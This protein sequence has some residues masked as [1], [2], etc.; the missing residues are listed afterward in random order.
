MTDFDFA[1]VNETIAAAIPEREALVWG[2]RRLTHRVLAERSRRFANFLLSRGLRVGQERKALAGHGARTTSR[3]TST[4]ATS[5]SRACSARTRRASRRSTSTTATSPTSSP[6]CSTTPTRARHLPRQLRAAARD[7]PRKLPPSSRCCSRSTTVGDDA[8]ARRASTTRRRWRPPGERRRSTPI[9]GRPLHPLH[10]RHDRHAEGRAVAAGRH[11]RRRAGR[12]ARR[13]GPSRDGRSSEMVDTR[14]RPHMR[15]LPAPPFMHGAAHWNAFIDLH[16]GGTVVMP[17]DTRAPRPRRHLAHRR[18]RAASARCRSSATPSRARCSTSSA[19]AHY[20][21]SRLRILG[22]GGAIL[23][24]LVQGGV[25]RAAAAPEDRRRLRLVGDRRARRR[26]AERRRR[27]TTRRLRRIDRTPCVARRR[28]HR[29]LARRRRRGRLARA[30]PAGC[31]SATSATPAKTTQHVPGDR[32]RPATRPRRPRPA[33]APTAR[34]ERPR[35]RL[36]DDQHRRREGLRRG[37]RAGAQAPPGRVRRRRR[38]PPERAL[39][40]GGRRPSCSSAPAS[41]ARRRPSCSRPRRA[42]R[43]LQAAEGDRLPST[44]SCAAR[45]A[46][47]TTA[48]RKIK[49]R[50]DERFGGG[51]D[52]GSCR[53]HRDGD[54]RGADGEAAARGG[55][56]ARGVRSRRSGHGPARRGGCNAGGEPARG[57]SDVPRRVHV[58]AGPGGGRGGRG[59]RG[60]HPRRRARGTSTST[61]L[62]RLDAVRSLAAREAAAGVHLVD[63]R[64]R[65]RG[66]RRAGT[67]TV[68]A[69]AAPRLRAR[70]EPRRRFGKHSSTS[71]SRGDGTLPPA[72]TTRSPAAGCWCRS[73]ALA[74]KAGLDSGQLLEVV[75]R[76]RRHVRRAG[77]SCFSAAAST[78]RSSSS[79]SP[80]RD[81]GLALASAKRA[82]RADGP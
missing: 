48:G 20:D 26:N 79:R 71:A 36:G 45:A 61:S 43:P 59:G 16:Q 37:G 78:T 42:P 1:T 27:A 75:R 70:G 82:R 33:A 18:A 77:R 12:P 80:G 72:W 57:G 17:S 58:A 66:R 44:R 81:V 9:A 38:R 62:E 39:G 19:R 60:R 69:T 30:A 8:A 34:I 14:R 13:T 63:A 68:M 55:A 10:R 6:T 21:L 67:L 52:V 40:R 74:A 24:P 15:T 32:R 53:L 76:A 28:T 47:P 25:P 2:K 23:S 65:R 41:D 51:E 4:T 64:L 35:P 7:D 46:S 49:P 54:H 50:R 73:F 31:R 29:V 11:L 22:S 56:C 3:S 5:T